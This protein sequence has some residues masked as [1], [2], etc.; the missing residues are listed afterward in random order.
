MGHSKDEKRKY[1]RLEVDAVIGVSVADDAQESSFEGF[2]A[3]AKN[4]SAEGICFVS[5]KQ[6]AVGG[7]LKVK[8]VLTEGS[9]PFF[10]KGEVKWSN[11][12]PRGDKTVFDIGVKILDIDKNDEQRFTSY[13]CSKMSEVLSKYLHL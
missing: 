7:I 1:I 5:D 9:E 13:V 2:S 8:V 10:L 11:S 4:I 3:S 6:L 12:V